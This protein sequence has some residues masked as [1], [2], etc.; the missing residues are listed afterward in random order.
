MDGNELHAL[1][2]GAARQL[3]RVSCLV[4]PAEPHLQRHGYAD[5]A[6]D[7]TDQGLRV[8]EIAHQ[9][10]ARKLAGHFPCRAAHVDVDEVGALG[11]GDAR[12]FRHPFLFAAGK[13]DDERGEVATFGPAQHI[14]ARF[15]EFFAGDH[16]GNDEGRAE[17]VR[18]PAKG[19]IADARHGSQHH[20]RRTINNAF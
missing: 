18:E 20:R 3:G 19:Q 8:V 1:G 11:F 7:G 14:G 6:Y 10:R 15:D 13:L 4:V 16:L 9:R 12:A 2:L 17:P 5:G